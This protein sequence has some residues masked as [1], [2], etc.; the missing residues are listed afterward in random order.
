M[1]PLLL[2]L[3]SVFQFFLCCMKVSFGIEI[4]ILRHRKLQHCFYDLIL[5]APEFRILLQRKVRLLLLPIEGQLLPV[6]LVPLFVE[7]RDPL[8]LCQL[9]HDLIHGMLCLFRKI[10]IDLFAGLLFQLGRQLAKQQHSLRRRRIAFSC[11]ND[12]LEQM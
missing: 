2:C 6:D 3:G 8:A 12:L 5:D 10:G 7:P 11:V 1:L 4:L 9:R